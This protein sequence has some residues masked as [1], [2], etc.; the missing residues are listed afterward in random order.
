MPISVSI[1]APSGADPRQLAAL[2]REEVSKAGREVGRR[3]AGALYDQ[4]DDM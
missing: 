1:T 3:L 2:V 4:P